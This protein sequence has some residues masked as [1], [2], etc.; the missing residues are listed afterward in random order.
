M[1]MT[2]MVVTTEINAQRKKTTRSIFSPQRF[3]DAT[4]EVI[5]GYH[6]VARGSVGRDLWRWLLQAVFSIC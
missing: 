4:N 2:Q 1:A 6:I 3:F 5:V